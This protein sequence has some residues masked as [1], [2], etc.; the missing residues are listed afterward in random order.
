M[1]TIQSI[2]RYPIKG[3]C[4]QALPSASLQSGLGMEGDRRFALRHGQTKFD[5]SL[6][7]YLPKTKFLALMTHAELAELKAEFG[8]DVCQ[9]K[10]SRAGET[11]FEGDLANAADA[12][13]LEVVINGLYGTRAKGTPRLVQ[14]DG[15]MF[16]D[17]PEKCLSIVNLASV[18]AL[19][20]H[21][22]VE[23][24]PLR[25]RA[26]IYLEGLAPWE[27]RHWEPGATFKVGGVSL[28][29]FKHIVRCNATNVNLETAKIDQNLPKALAKT[30]DANLMGVY[31]FVAEDGAVSVGDTFSPV[32]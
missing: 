13:R 24:D 31:C 9:L 17:V 14:A 10:L 30:F 22:G 11:V 25:F 2:Y 32:S 19:G 16:S 12:E 20:D 27:E 7:E 8:D 26:N 23:L 15:H 28:N 4:G 21:L 29:L 6:P 18:R 3:L 1:A 5:P